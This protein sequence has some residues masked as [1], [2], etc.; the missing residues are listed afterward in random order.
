VRAVRPQERPLGCWAGKFVFGRAVR[1]VKNGHLEVGQ[2]SLF[3]V[4]RSERCAQYVRKN[5][6]LDV[7]QVSLFLVERSETG[8]LACRRS[9]P[10][11]WQ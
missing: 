10:K 9:Q 11:Q 3:L 1:E 7:G 5:G 2:A 4:E 8:T 6:H